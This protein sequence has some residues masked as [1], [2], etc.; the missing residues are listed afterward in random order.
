MADSP[1]KKTTAKSTAAKP[2]KV[3]AKQAETLDAQSALEQYKLIEAYAKALA[4]QAI[5]DPDGKKSRR[6]SRSYGSYTKENIESY[7]SSPTQNEEA[8]RNASIFLYYA[9]TRYRN[10][11]QY[12]ANIPCWCYVVNAVGFNPD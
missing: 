9:H 8:L 7:L 4:A 3:A 12:Y 2:K 6:T 11:L 5:N 10:L 1:K